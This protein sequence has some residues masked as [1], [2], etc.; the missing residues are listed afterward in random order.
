[1]P[2]SVSHYVLVNVK[3]GEH[4]AFFRLFGKGEIE[5]QLPFR[6]K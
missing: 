5:V 4:L 2:I 3:G 6:L 1:M